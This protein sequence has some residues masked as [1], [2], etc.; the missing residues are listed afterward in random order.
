MKTVLYREESY[1]ILGACFAVYKEMGCGFLESV[2]QECLE[3]EMRER[4]I[5]FAAQHPLHLSYRGSILEQT[6]ATDF[7]CYDV[8]ILE[9]KAVAN[10]T[11]AH[12]A[13]TLNYLHATGLELGLLVNFGHHPLLEHERIALTRPPDRIH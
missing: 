11:D 10:L 5:P 2:Y 4:G 13:Q 9:L 6:Y 8:I 1:A 7:L 3:I 12:R